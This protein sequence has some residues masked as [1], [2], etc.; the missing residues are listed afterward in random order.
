[1]KKLLSVLLLAIII[2]SVS[3][4]NKPVAETVTV[5]I[6]GSDEVVYEVDLNKVDVTE[7]AFSVLKYLNENEGLNLASESGEFGPYLTEV[8][9]LKNDSVNGMYIY[10]YTSVEADKDTSEYAMNHTYNGVELTSA[11]VG[12][13]QMKVEKDS[14]IYFGLIKF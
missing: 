9:S 12:I 5:V 2:V 7:G 14:I 3:A 10:I 13:S 8:G 1:M 6:G 11:K 4:C